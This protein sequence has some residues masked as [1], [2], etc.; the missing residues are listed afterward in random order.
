VA[1]RADLEAAV[2]AGLISAEQAE[3]LGDFLSAR[4]GG[5]L[6]PAPIAP[7]GEEDLRFIRNFHD[8]FLSIGI[9]LVAV[10]LS[11]VVWM[12][13]S[14]ITVQSRTFSTTPIFIAAGLLAGA[15]LVMWVLAEFF[16]GR[17]RL[18]LPSIALC[19]TFTV[20]AV[21]AFGMATFGVDYAVFGTWDNA[22]LDSLPLITRVSFALVALSVSAAALLFYWRFKL[23]FSLSIVGLGGA[24][25]AGALVYL[26]APHDVLRALAPIALFCGLALFGAGVAFDMRD[27]ERATRLS[28]N[29]F[30]LHMAAAPLILNGAIGCVSNVILGRKV[31]LGMFAAGDGPLLAS[32]TLIVVAVLGFASLLINRRALIVSALLTTGIAVSALLNEV[33]MGASALAA[34]TLLTLGIGVLVLGAGW[35]GARRALLAGVPQ[36]TMLARLF[37]PESRE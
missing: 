17:R 19:V 20:F 5:A 26:A 7:S 2:A 1:S 35:H 37:P 16:A 24:L 34:A 3:P 18:F 15:A 23:P 13:V 8:V 30:W 29:G 25:T 32:A 12:T 10:G 4:A 33:G 28:D 9:L 31:A 11:I 27:P 22:R 6:S 36:G 14:S 21:S